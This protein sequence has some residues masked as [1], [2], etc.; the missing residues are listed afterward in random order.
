MS[1][2]EII[3]ALVQGLL[4][5]VGAFAGVLVC[6]MPPSQRR[7]QRERDDQMNEHMLEMRGLYKRIAVAM[8]RILEMAEADRNL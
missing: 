4:F 5:G 1:G 2:T 6:L 8:E 3:T 7:K